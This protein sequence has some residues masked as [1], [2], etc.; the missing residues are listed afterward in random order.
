VVEAFFSPPRPGDIVWCLFP[1]DRKLVPGPK[2]RPALVVRIGEIEGA[3]AVVVAYGTSRRVTELHAGEFA[4]SR[5]DG[6]AFKTSGL[7]FDTKFDLSRLVELPFTVKWFG[8]PPGAPHGQTPKLGLLHP[9]L[10][11]RASAAFS[12]AQKA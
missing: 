5:G 1:E 11:R 7:S 9:T 3:P 8:V 12:A 6:D 2:P 4:I 10:M